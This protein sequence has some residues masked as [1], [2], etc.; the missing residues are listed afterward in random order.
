MY[1]NNLLLSRYLVNSPFSPE[2]AQKG[3]Y[4]LE[5]KESLLI[6]LV[7]SKYNMYQEP[8]I[9]Q[10]PIS[11]IGLKKIKQRLHCFIALHFR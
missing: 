1:I 9:I 3:F 2:L 6:Y 10:T 5:P 11:Y 7:S 8:A 4:K